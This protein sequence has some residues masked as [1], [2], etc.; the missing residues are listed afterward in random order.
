MTIQASVL[1]ACPT[2]TGKLPP[3]SL[4][5]AVQTHSRVACGYSRLLSKGADTKPV[6]LHP[7]DRLA[8]LRLQGVHQLDHAAA[9]DGLEFRIWRALLALVLGGKAVEGAAPCI[10]P[11]IMVRESVT[12]YPVKPR[13]RRG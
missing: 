10:L 7:A 9:D 1:E 4:P 13:G 5:G 8:I 11:A 3:K 12:K 2:G 6:E